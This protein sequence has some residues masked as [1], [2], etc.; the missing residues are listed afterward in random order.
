MTKETVIKIKSEP[1]VREIIF[2][3]D[4]SDKCLISKIYK[5]LM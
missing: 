4:S 3:N 2:A 5:E 1:T